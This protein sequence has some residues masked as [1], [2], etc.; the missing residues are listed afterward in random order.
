MD[1]C[2]FQFNPCKPP[3]FMDVHRGG[4]AD[5]FLPGLLPLNVAGDPPFLAGGIEPNSKA[6]HLG[7][8]DYAFALWRFLPCDM[9]GQPPTGGFAKVGKQC[10]VYPM[11]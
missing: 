8:P 3:S 5:G 10:T 6:G 11:G 1:R 2:S 9:A 4:I 7:I